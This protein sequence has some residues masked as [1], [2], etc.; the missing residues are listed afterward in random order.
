MAKVFEY[1]ALAV[2]ELEE[3]DVPNLARWLSD[4]R[5]LE[6]VEGRDR[7]YDVARVREKYLA[8]RGSRITCCIVE[9]DRA[10]I[11]YIQ[12][13]P[14][15]DGEKAGY[16]Y[17]RTLRI[18]GIDLFIGLPELWGQGI[19]TELVTAMTEYLSN[20]RKADKIAIDPRTWNTRA[21]HCYEKS[22]FRKVKLLPAHELHE[23]AMRDCWLMEQGRV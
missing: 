9:W 4:P 14:L 18:Y 5:V 6:Y 16:G 17:Q 19:G 23:G 1:G 13:Y 7:P 10:A 2:R 8:R 3:G 20:V 22:G 11:G 15:T 21:I 12:F